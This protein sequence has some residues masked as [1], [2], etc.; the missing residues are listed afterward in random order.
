MGCQPPIPELIT[1]TGSVLARHICFLQDDGH[2]KA[3]AIHP[4]IRNSL[5]W[6]S[7]TQP[8]CRLGSSLFNLLLK[9]FPSRGTF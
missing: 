8:S 4:E 2:F 7:Y 3:L 1:L 9:F 6:P 5:Q